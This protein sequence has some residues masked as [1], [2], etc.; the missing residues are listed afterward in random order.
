MAGRAPDAGT[1]AELVDGAA[2]LVRRAGDRTSRAHACFY[3]GLVEDV[4]R[5][6]AAAADGYYRLALDTDDDFVRSFALRHLGALADDAGDRDRAVSMWREST[7]LRVDEL[8]SDQIVNSWADALGVDA[9]LAAAAASEP[10]VA[11]DRN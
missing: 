5:N 9:L 2:E 11:R 8:S 1:V 6:T 7:R 4:L 3:R 10:E